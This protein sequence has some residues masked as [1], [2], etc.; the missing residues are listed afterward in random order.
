MS[1]SWHCT[2]R[3]TIS[4]RAH[5]WGLLTRAMDIINE[6][7][8]MNRPCLVPFGHLYTVYSGWL[9]KTKSRAS[10]SEPVL[11]LRMCH[12]SVP[13]TLIW[14]GLTGAV[15]RQDLPHF[16]WLLLH[17]QS[18]KSR[19]MWRQSL[20]TKRATTQRKKIRKLDLS[21]LN[22]QTN[23]IAAKEN[24]H[25]SEDSP[26]NQQQRTIIDICIEDQRTA[27]AQPNEDS[28]RNEA[29]RRVSLAFKMVMTKHGSGSGSCVAVTK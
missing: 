9:Q 14:F 24:K 26:S 13:V 4:S 7:Q 21:Q 20:K 17:P 6:T 15:Q 28:E 3:S 29:T 11:C 16:I 5:M 2:T 27:T 8:Q 23:R 12:L 1:C 19:R 18:E 22:L 25:R 10:K